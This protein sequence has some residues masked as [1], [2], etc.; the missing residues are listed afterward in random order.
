V[1]ETNDLGAVWASAT[2]EIASAQH[3]AYLRLTQLRAIVEDTALV[4]VPDAYTR[5]II[6]SK[7]LR[8]AITDALSRRLGRPIQVAVTVRPRR[9]AP[10][11]LPRRTAG[12]AGTGRA[13]GGGPAAGRP[14]GGPGSP[15]GRGDPL[16]CAA[17]VRLAGQYDGRPATS[18]DL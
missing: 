15:L 5:D 14:G 8:P 12:I 16:R 2:D 11:R 9:T 3:R 6:E 1:A 17:G 7:Q 4:A 13:A 18:P 10:G